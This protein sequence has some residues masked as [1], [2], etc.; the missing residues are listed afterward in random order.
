MQKTF[1]NYFFVRLSAFFLLTTQIWPIAQPKVCVLTEKINGIVFSC[2]NWPMLLEISRDRK[3]SSVVCVSCEQR[4]V[5]GR[6]F[7][8]MKWAVDWFLKFLNVLPEKFLNWKLKNV[9]REIFW[10]KKCYPGNFW[11]E[12][13]K[14]AIR[15][16]FEMEIKQISNKETSKINALNKNHKKF[17]KPLKFQHFTFELWRPPASNT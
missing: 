6:L 17:A 9:I 14:F 2:L 7:C 12:N 11:T 1:T 8:L 13:K 16:T 10:L 15:E 5:K 4:V 3:C